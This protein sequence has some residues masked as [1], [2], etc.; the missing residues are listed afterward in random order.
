[1]KSRGI[2]MIPEWTTLQ[3]I[4]LKEGGRGFFYMRH[5]KQE[6]LLFVQLEVSRGN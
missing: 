3:C 5:T 2:E 1:M 6:T 4:V